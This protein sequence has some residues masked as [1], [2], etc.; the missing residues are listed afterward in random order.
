MS[1]F[2]VR[3]GERISITTQTVNLEMPDLNAKGMLK[4]R[5]TYEATA[6]DEYQE[7]AGVRRRLFVDSSIDFGFGREIWLSDG[8]SAVTPPANDEWPD[9]VADEEPVLS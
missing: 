6:T 4:T 5:V 7:I 8:P 3:A 9:I 1:I 2:S